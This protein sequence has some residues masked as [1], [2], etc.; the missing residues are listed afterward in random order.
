MPVLG[1]A[2]VGLATA[3]CTK[4][5]KVASVGAALWLP[6]IVGLAYLPDIVN[7]LA[8]T[9]GLGNQQIVTHS[10]LFAAVASAVIAP[11]LARLARCS[12]LK[13]LPLTLFAILSHV[14]LDILQGS[15]RELWWPMSSQRMQLES[16]IIPVGLSAELKLFGGAYIVFWVCLFVVTRWRAAQRQRRDRLA[17]A[18]RAQ[19]ASPPPRPKAA[20]PNA[21]QERS[22]QH[23]VWAGRIAIALILLTAAATHYLQGI[24]ERQ[25]ASAMSLLRKHD[26]PAALA[27]IKKTE[28]WPYLAAPGWAE[29][30]KAQAYEG[31]GNRDLAEA[32]Y[33]AALRA[34]PSSFWTLAA[35]AQFYASGKEP[36]ADRR[37]N[38]EPYLQQLRTRFFWHKSQPIILRRLDRA[39]ADPPP[40]RIPTP[41]RP[42]TPPPRR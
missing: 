27:M 42:K 34:D 32:Y 39:L 16:R 29:Y 25:L 22:Y 35:L 4:P 2:F 19:A 28:Q 38:A 37:R 36:L 21:R 13:A 41:N 3:Q 11:A 9:C 18:R 10:L 6:I 8:I 7:Q 20:I 30:T 12:L 15:V 31:M 24:R 17:S 40:P 1:H 14:A 5:A 23:L 26:Y 33:L